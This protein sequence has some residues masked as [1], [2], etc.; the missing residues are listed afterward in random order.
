MTR[1][2]RW[3]ADEISKLK[4]C[5][6]RDLTPKQAAEIVGRPST[7]CLGKAATLGLSLAKESRIR[8]TKR[9]FEESVRAEIPPA[10]R[11][12]SRTAMMFGDPPIG[13]SALDQKRAGQ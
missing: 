11:Y 2:T 13:R 3:T 12:A 8:R 6:E 7:A 4:E 9:D 10:P 1:G 5:C